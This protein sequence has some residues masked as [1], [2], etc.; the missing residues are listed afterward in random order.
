MLG[1]VV[2]ICW[3]GWRENARGIGG[4]PTRNEVGLHGGKGRGGCEVI[5]GGVQGRHG[6]KDRGEAV[7][8]RHV[9][10]VSEW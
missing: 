7:V 3:V 4:C 2:V 6:G 10:V 5:G 1:V 9:I 8:R